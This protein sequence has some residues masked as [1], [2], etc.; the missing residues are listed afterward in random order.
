MVE[1]LETAAG[2]EITSFQPIGKPVGVAAGSLELIRRGM[3]KVVN[4]PGGTVYSSGRSSL[5]Q[6]AGKTGTA[7]VRGKR[8]KEE[9]ALQ[10]WH[11][12]RDHAWFAGF[13]P[14]ENPEIAVVVLVEHGGSG[15]R[16]ASPVA[17]DII[18]GYL[19]DVKGVPRPPEPG[20]AP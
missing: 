5:V 13:A 3:W 19:H 12:E 15:G 20:T 11:P 14:A 7:Q 16:T 9:E 8:S 2:E 1:R 18:E 17:R 10:G 4:E 6:F